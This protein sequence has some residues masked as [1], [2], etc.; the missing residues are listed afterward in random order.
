MAPTIAHGAPSG[1]SSRY[2]HSDDIHTVDPKTAHQGAGDPGYTQWLPNCGTCQA[3]TLAEAEAAGIDAQT[4][5]NL[6]G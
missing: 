3:I 6:D 2:E 5:M 4:E 1:F